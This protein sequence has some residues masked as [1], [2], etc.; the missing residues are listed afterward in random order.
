MSESVAADVGRAHPFPK[1]QG[2]DRSIQD[3]DRFGRLVSKVV[4]E[5]QEGQLPIRN[6]LVAVQQVSEDLKR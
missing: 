2:D 4:E 3:R 5:S 1:G 6:D